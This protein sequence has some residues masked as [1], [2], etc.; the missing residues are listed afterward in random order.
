MDM[1]LEFNIDTYYYCHFSSTAVTMLLLLLL[2]LVYIG[3]IGSAGDRI[4][5]LAE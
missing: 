4:G 3:D 2:L 1:R 5:I